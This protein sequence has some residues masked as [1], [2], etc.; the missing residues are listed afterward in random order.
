MGLA[1]E[2]FVNVAEYGAKGDGVHDDTEAINNCIADNYGKT[3]NFGSGTYIITNSI[4]LPFETDKKVSINGNGAIIKT[5]GDFGCVFD[6][7]KKLRSDINNNNVGFPSY[8]QDLTIDASESNIDY[9]FDIE[10]GFKDFKIKNCKTYRTINGIRIGENNS[11][12]N[13][14]FIEDCLI[15]GKGSEHYS[16]GIISNATDNNIIN[17]RIYGFRKGFEVNGYITINQ[18]HVLLRWEKQTTENFDPYERNSE[19]FNEHYE[20]TCFAKIEA[21]CK[22]MNCYCDSTYKFIEDDSK[23]RYVTITNSFYYNARHN[24]DCMLFD[25]KGDYANYN[26]SDNVFFISR[27]T[28]GIGIKKNPYFNNFSQIKLHNNMIQNI[29]N[30]SNPG[31]LLKANSFKYK[32]NNVLKANTWTVIGVLSNVQPYTACVLDVYIYNYLYKIRLQL[33]NELNVDNIQQWLKDNDTDSA[34][35]IGFVKDEENPDVIYVCIKR[36]SDIEGVKYSVNVE[37]S[38]NL[39]YEMIASKNSNPITDNGLLTNFTNNIPGTTLKL[40]SS[41][42]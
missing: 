10:T 16:T 22:I 21:D 14:T 3:I 2:N 12:P 38:N 34:Y 25:F 4:N 7:G 42:L 31:D 20:K 23:G 19:L 33:D 24:V 29:T 37:S 11:S 9:A 28:K 27:N 6:V 30:L 13:D 32:T 15:Y 35:E 8:V 1:L 41:L 5:I 26:I 17:T 36:D 40:K 18:C 39:I